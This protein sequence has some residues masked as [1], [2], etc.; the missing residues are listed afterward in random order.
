MVKILVKFRTFINVVWEKE[1]HGEKA[2]AFVNGFP[3]LFIL[4][5]RR[6]IVIGEYMEKQGWLK[7]KTVR[8]VIFE[9]SLDKLKNFSFDFNLKTHK[10][11]GYISFHEHNQIG[12]G[13][14]IMFLKMNKAISE[15]ITNHFTEI[16]VK[17]PL[18][19]SGIVIIDEDVEDSV[20]WLNNRLGKT[21]LGE[22]AL[23][24]KLI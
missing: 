10:F 17:N 19:D 6:A 3:G 14:L 22:E 12:E 8:K 21:R 4:T 5:Q 9:A 16:N 23:R 15:A 24:E 1:Q 11:S 7:K 13:A 20:A 18:N 2:M